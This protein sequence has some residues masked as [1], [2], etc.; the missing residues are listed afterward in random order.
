MSDDKILR[1]VINRKAGTV[2]GKE[3]P[4]IH[5]NFFAAPTNK[6]LGEGLRRAMESKG[7]A[8]NINDSYNAKRFFS[9]T[10]ER[11]FIYYPV[12]RLENSGQII[13]TVFRVG[14]HDL[15]RSCEAIQTVVLQKDTPCNHIEGHLN[16]S[17]GP[18]P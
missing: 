2:E 8:W 12:E 4:N 9:I 5:P 1:L 6:T 16:V 13:C 17:I 3:K 7:I 15:A 10:G 11:D 18:R 14:E